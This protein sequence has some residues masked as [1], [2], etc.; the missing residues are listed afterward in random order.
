MA[1]KTTPAKKLSDKNTK[2]EML[3]A[4]QTLA[5]QLEEKRQTELN[6]ERKLEEKKTQEALKAA[7]TV[8]AEGIDREIG[9][10]KSEI[11]SMLAEVS[12]KLGTEAT[13]F[14]NV[15]K[16]VEAKEAELR[17]LYGIEKAASTLAALIE[18]QNQKRRD[19]ETETAQ[20]HEALTGEIEETRAAWQKERQAHEAE[21]RERD[22][23]EK[24]T[25]DREKEQFDY[26]FKRE[27]QTWR[28]KLADERAALEKELRLKKETAE[29]ELTERE[30][31]VK[32]QE[33]EL[34]TLR[35]KSAAFPKELETAV[36]QAVREMSDKL[37]LE[38]KN[39]EELLKKEFEGERNVLT[40]RVESLEKT[41]KELA[42][43]NGRMN[44]QL[45]GAYQ[46]VQEIAEKTIE[47]AGHAK[48]FTELQKLLVDQGR[49]AAAE[50]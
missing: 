44:K 37:K 8:V 23:A 42:E 50:K 4:Y 2:Q 28:D 16:A 38:A 7:S 24:K 31:A 32:A 34:N 30:Q 36:N 12:E 3:E 45:E 5:K 49:K 41:A 17:E 13:R 18:A 19:F 14:R 20:Q 6:P 40:A 43:Q 15:Q 22:A 11:S 21:V 46:K 26:A 27:Q 47:S 10:L 9:G 39:R 1:E 25:R 35:T 33:A 48:S 29:K